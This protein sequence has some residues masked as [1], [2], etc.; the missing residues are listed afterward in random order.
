M[1]ISALLTQ[2]Q[3]MLL[4][5]LRRG[6]PVP[7]LRLI[8]LLYGDRPDG[9]P[10]DPAGTISVQLCKLRA[11]LAPH[12]IAILTV[13][14]DGGYMVHPAHLERLSQLLA[15]WLP[16]AIERAATAEQAAFA[17]H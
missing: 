13:G 15:A 16:Q 11:R 17:F 9:G 8:A 6:H 14:R 3:S 10:D 2:Q 12:G 5:P 4:E 1:R 7:M